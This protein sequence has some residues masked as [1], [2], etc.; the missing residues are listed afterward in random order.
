M[1]HRVNPEKMK[2]DINTHL[3]RFL[4]IPDILP[5]ADNTSIYKSMMNDTH[6]IS[7][8][9]NYPADPYGILEH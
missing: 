2:R 4:R 7:A 6:L 3:R 8:L 1:L 9:E 5:P